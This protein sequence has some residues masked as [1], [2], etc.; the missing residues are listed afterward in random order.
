MLSLTKRV[1]LFLSAFFL[2]TNKGN[3]VV[4]PSVNVTVALNATVVPAPCGVPTLINMNEVG[5]TF[6]SGIVDRT[7][8]SCRRNKRGAM[9]KFCVGLSGCF[10]SVLHIG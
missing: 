1:L 10:Y 2:F 8:R 7:A 3:A 9:L 6:R 4:L 5:Y